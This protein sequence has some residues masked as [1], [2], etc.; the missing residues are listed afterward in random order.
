[1]EALTRTYHQAVD[2]LEELT[3][4]DGILA[5]TIEADNYKRVWAR[6]SLICGIAGLLSNNEVVID[7]L[8]QSLLT[9]AAHQNEHGMIPSNV[10]PGADPADV[11]FGSLVGRV[12]ANTWF[13]VG[14][15][16]YLKH[17]EDTATSD[18][19]MPAIKACRRYLNIHELNNKGWLYTP[20]SGNWADEFP[21][22]GYTLYDNALRLWGESLW[23]QLQGSSDFPIETLLEKTQV[24]FWPQ[25]EADSSKIY[26]QQAYD[27][28]LGVPHYCAQI[29][30]GYYETRFDAAANGL[31]LLLFPLKAAQKESLNGFISELSD[32]INS[33]MMPAFWPPIRQDDW[34]WK[35]LEGNYSFD[36]KNHPHQF[37]NGGIWPVW[38]GWWSL[39]L[40][41]HGL[42]DAVQNLTEAF[43]QYP[44]RSDW[45]FQEYIRSDNF[46]LAGKQQMG[47]TASGIVFMYYALHTTNFSQTLGL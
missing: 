12:D 20:L 17:R 2:L 46:E 10:L 26:Q 1:M 33:P 11:S 38:M 23:Q 13:I 5:S 18:I 21:V 41:N 32:E 7:G 19:L 42:T 15:C 28:A 36:F 27:R 30:P 43:M 25:P 14:A 6:D 34:D 44:N 3:T 35:L 16:L 8:K 47:F 24:N 22:Q 40:A 9:L 39:G 31:A 37:H 29:L 45:D 4:S